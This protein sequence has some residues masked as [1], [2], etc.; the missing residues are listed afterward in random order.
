MAPDFDSGDDMSMTTA[1]LLTK[2][3]QGDCDARRTVI[4]DNLSLVRSVAYK[5][6]GRGYEAED[7]FQIGCI[8]MVKAVDKFD[9]SYNVQFSTY[10]V[11]LIMGEIKRFLRDDGIIKVS[12]SL[13]ELS[14]R[15]FA[16]KESAEK[17]LGRLVTVSEIAERLGETPEKILM[18]ME[19]TLPPESIYKQICEGDS[20][21]ICL[22]DRLADEQTDEDTMIDA[23][24][25]TQ[26]LD[27][28]CPRDRKLILLRYFKGKTQR[29]ISAILGISQV[30]VS[31]LEKRILDTLR[32]KLKGA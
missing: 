20:G 11:P 1:E 16:I 10:A 26:H 9:A 32:I 22:A 13:K 15:A 5:F 6:S 18:A 4:E 19:S 3:R 8:G 17:E 27:E 23:I 30:Q 2:A 7:L 29:E 31:R 25:L 24:T 28:L 12:R 14:Y 21:D